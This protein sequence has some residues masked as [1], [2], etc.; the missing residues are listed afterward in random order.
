ML[1]ISPIVFPYRLIRQEPWHLKNLLAGMDPRSTGYQERTGHL[2]LVKD[3]FQKSADKYRQK[4]ELSTNRID[5]FKLAIQ[6]LG[7]LR[8][9]HVLLGEA[10]DA[11]AMKKKIDIWRAKME[12]DSKK[13]EQRD[14]AARVKKHAK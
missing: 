2:R 5:D 11:Q 6:Y 10:E 3:L 12:S 1:D 9:L 4:Y 13:L 14:R 8:R 7:G